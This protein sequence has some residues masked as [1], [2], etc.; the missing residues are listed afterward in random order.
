ML[1]FIA[2]LSYFV[3]VRLRTISAEVF[4]SGKGFFGA[5]FTFFANLGAVFSLLFII[6]ISTC[7]CVT[8]HLSPWL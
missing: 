8:N 2:E 5:A 4:L 1:C 3:L 6:S 7:T